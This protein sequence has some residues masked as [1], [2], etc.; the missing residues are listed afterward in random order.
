LDPSLS[1]NFRPISNLNNISK[2]LESLFLTRLQLHIDLPRNFNPFQLAY[3]KHHSTETSLI[4]L[5][6][7][8][9]H[10]ADN[11]LTTLLLSLD[12][13]AAF[14]TID[15][16]IL[17]NSLTLVLASWVLLTIGSSLISLTG[18]FQSPLAQLPS[19]SYGHLV[20][21]HKALSWVLFFSQSM[22]HLLL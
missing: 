18:H 5:L 22:S 7:S 2:I 17:L 11:G 8:I 1:A 14:D 19:P 10:A 9:Y 4:H 15:H 6:D 12:L 21:I 3:H 20:V 16:V 13:G